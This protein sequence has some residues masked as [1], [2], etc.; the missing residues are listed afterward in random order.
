MIFA[1]GIVVVV[2]F[3]I[4]LTMISRRGQAVGGWIERTLLF[5]M[6]GYAA[7]RAIIGGIANGKS[8]SVVRPALLTLGEGSECF[9]AVTEDHGG[10]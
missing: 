8:E 2:S 9:V 5:R 3:A 7:V 1:V 4:R 6:P 10:G